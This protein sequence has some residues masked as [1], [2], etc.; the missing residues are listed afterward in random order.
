VDTPAWGIY[1]YRVTEIT[2]NPLWIAPEGVR[3]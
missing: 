3:G 1:R 2:K